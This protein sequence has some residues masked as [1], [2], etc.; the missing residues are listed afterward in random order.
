[1]ADNRIFPGNKVS[2]NHVTTIILSEMRRSRAAMGEGEG[3]TATCPTPRYQH[4]T[5]AEESDFRHYLLL[6]PIPDPKDL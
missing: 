1:M 5:W 6:S 4:L 2:D 3:P